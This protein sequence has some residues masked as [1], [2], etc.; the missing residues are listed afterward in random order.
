MQIYRWQ[1]LRTKRKCL[2]WRN[3]QVSLHT[4]KTEGRSV[5]TSEFSW[6]FLKATQKG[7]VVFFIK[8]FFSPIQQHFI[9]FWRPRKRW[10]RAVVNPKSQ[11]RS[12]RQRKPSFMHAHL[13]SNCCWSSTWV[14]GSLSG[15]IL[16]TDI[17]RKPELHRGT[18]NIE[19]DIWQIMLTSCH[20]F[21]VST[22][23]KS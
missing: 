5:W 15:E 6:L 1:T 3:S 17:F 14:N 9:C 10:V 12:L 22:P 23:T 16:A 8:Q 13:W 7:H 21:S 2:S 11:T 18:L 20:S 4:I 19:T